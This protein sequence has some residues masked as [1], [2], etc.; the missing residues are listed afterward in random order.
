MSFAL[1]T[2]AKMVANALAMQGWNFLVAG[3]P[4]LPAVWPRVL[5]L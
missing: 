4:G 1:K 5:L 2:F 3:T